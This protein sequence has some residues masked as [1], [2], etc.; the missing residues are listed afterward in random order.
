[1]AAVDAFGMHSTDHPR[2]SRRTYRRTRVALL[3]TCLTIMVIDVAG[4]QRALGAGIPSDRGPVPT[5]AIRPSGHPAPVAPRA[6]LVVARPP[7]QPS[8]T[9][10]TT[11]PRR[12][13]GAVAATA[14]RPA[15]PRP[16]PPVAVPVPTPTVAPSPAPRPQP[17]PTTTTTTA[18]PPPPAQKPPASSDPST[19]VPPSQ[20]FQQACWVSQPDI[21]ACN[22]AA[23]TDIDNARAGEGLGPLQLPSGFYSLP[24]ASQLVA[25]ANAERTS[26]GLPALPENSGLDRSAQQGAASGQDPTGP[27]GY[28]WDSN[29][30]LGDPT[31]LAADF[32]WMYDDG[33]GSGNVDCTSTN[34]SGCWGHRNNILSPW[35]GSAGGGMATY[36]GRTALAQLFVEAPQG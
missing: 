10:V 16:L 5:R 2:Q 27:P 30:A 36:Q 9:T 24:V 34:H 11:L 20:A 13:A 21:Q 17:A 8:T 28:T 4:A 32:S 22:Q 6:D 35:P 25:V 15:P 23:L 12:E 26:R 14:P 19:S 18:P 31:A 7:A 29:Y 1:M 3:T 33:P